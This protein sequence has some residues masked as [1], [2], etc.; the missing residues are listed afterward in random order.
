MAKTAEEIKDL[1][2]TPLFVEGQKCNYISISE[3]GDITYIEYHCK[4]GAK[5]KLQN[6][7]ESVQATAFLRL[8]ME[9]NYS[10]LNISVNEAVQVGSS[11]KEADI[12]VYSQDNKKILIVVECKEEGINERQ[13]QVAID[14]AYAYAHALAGQYV[15]VTSGIRHEYFERKRFYET[16]GKNF[17]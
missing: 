17:P 5:R 1:L 15:W 9:Y 11:T 12:L 3:K 13:F 7:E 16:K 4:N 6:P 14:Q 2:A 10:P 8:I